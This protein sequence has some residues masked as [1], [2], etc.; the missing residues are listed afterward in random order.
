RRRWAAADEALGKRCAGPL[1]TDTGGGKDPRRETAIDPE[2]RLQDVLGADVVVVERARLDLGE[3]EHLARLS[4][5]AAERL[6]RSRIAALPTADEPSEKR[7]GTSR[8]RGVAGVDDL[9]DALVAEPQAF[10]DLPHAGAAGVQTADR[11]VVVRTRAFE[12][13]LVLEQSGSCAFGLGQ[14][15]FIER[16]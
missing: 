5:K 11:E 9:V 8:R 2:Q 3:L 14:Q 13:V 15:S 12:F 6:G 10:G 1:D 16:H 4:G 7:L